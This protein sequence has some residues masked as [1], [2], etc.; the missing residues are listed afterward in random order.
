T[1]LE[2]GGGV[3]LRGSLPGPG[4]PFRVRT[5][6]Y[7]PALLEIP[8]RLAGQRDV[9]LGAV[10]LERGWTREV[11]LVGEERDALRGARISISPV[12]APEEEQIYAA[13][14]SGRALAGGLQRGQYSIA[15]D[16][17]ALRP[18]LRRVDLFEAELDEPLEISVERT[19]V[20]EVRVWG[21]VLD[22]DAFTAVRCTVVERYTIAGASMP[23]AMPPYPLT[24]DGRFGS[25]RELR[26]AIGVHVSVLSP[27]EAAAEA[28]RSRVSGPALFDC[29]EL[30]LAP[31]PRGDVTFVADGLGKV[32]PPVHVSLEG[33][34]GI[35]SIARFRLGYH[36]LF[37]DNLRHG[38]YQ[39]RWRDESGREESCGWYVPNRFG[40]RIAVEAK[41][42]PGSEEWVETRIVDAE[43][44]P[45]EG[46][47]VDP[48]LPP[49]LGALAG[50]DPEGRAPGA[51]LVRVT[52]RSATRF[53]VE[54]AGFLDA[55]VELGP[56]EPVPDPVTLYRP[57]AA[58]GRVLDHDGVDVDGVLL[59]SWEP[60]RP[61]PVRHGRE[62]EI[63][64][65]GGRFE[66]GGFPPLTLRFTF[67]LAGS[68]VAV[69][70]HLALTDRDAREPHD[71]GIIRLEETRSLEG[72]VYRPDGTPAAGATAALVE[73]GR[74]H[75]YPLRDPL[76]LTRLEHRAKADAQ[77]VFR[78]EA[79]PLELP[80][81][82]VLLA[83]LDGH[84]DAVE[85]PIDWDA[86]ARDLV[87]EPEAVLSIDV[88][89]RSRIAPETH[90]FR[91][92]YRDLSR[93]AEELTELGELEPH[94]FGLHFF[95]GV[96]PGGY[97]V[98]WGLRDPY[99]PLPALWEDVV[100]PAG[101]SARLA[102]SL[103]G[104][105]LRGSASLNGR[106]VPKGWF[107]L[108]YDP[109]E[110]GGTRVGRIVDGEYILVDPPSSMRAYGAVIPETSPQARQN[111]ARGE[112]VP[113]EI[114]GYLQ[115]MRAGR[116]DFDYHAHSLTLRFAPQFLERHPGA[117]FVCDGY[118]WERG[119]LRK[120]ERREPI[121]EPTVRLLLL[122][123]GI[124]R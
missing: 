20:E 59:V 13:D 9:D 50:G 49:A 100:L 108:T 95:S 24:P 37:I 113:V 101:G 21:R 61:E 116:L 87:L 66:A 47:S 35:E 23:V 75:R 62:L 25:I 84:G 82:L 117:V 16:G 58:R 105:T 30:R 80:E 97:R 68:S 5:R 63:P 26:G 103:Q 42:S 32:A 57:V 7:L 94:L 98:T 38:R 39:L 70:R 110:H 54:A 15:V 53:R 123:P 96:R 52:P 14:E 41:R 78:L 111:L 8:E 88:G 3:E 18:V 90:R 73:R 124:Q 29:G 79:L 115:A 10:I 4:D 74:A 104:S 40:G 118:E 109:G 85:D 92:Y 19:E 64:V 44:R 83:R 65:A 112:A 55:S 34:D 77:G 43:G 119:R 91:L 89:Y 33:E 60:L 45:V 67:R 17:P 81:S 36:R 107:L 72:V 56:G 106:A 1:R 120:V 121:L 69:A 2:P 114:R 27:T 31:R 46:A 71:L 6:G 11:R 22:V 48:A 76:D 122:T 93:G 86:P 12:D 99:D 51:V 28:V 102:L